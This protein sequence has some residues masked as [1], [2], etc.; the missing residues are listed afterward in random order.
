MTPT[1]Q[2][3]V[4]LLWWGECFNVMSPEINIIAAV[5]ENR[6][7]GKDGKLPWHI[8]ADMKRFRELTTGYPIIMGRKTFEGIGRALPDRPNI[9]ITHDEQFEAPGCV[10][11]HSLEEAIR[12][13]EES[14]DKVFIIGGEQIFEQALDVADRLY[15]TVVAG[16]F[17]GDAFFPDYSN[18][19]KVVSKEEGKEGKFK[20]EFVVF[21]R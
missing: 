17:E 13:A 2:L 3:K 1:R 16:E 20:F 12:A 10:I 8:S 14:S 15:L 18:F 11:C 9:V 19:Q 5:S 21:E 6:V 4:M 7:I